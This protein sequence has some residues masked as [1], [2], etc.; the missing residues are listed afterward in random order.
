MF[1]I[2]RTFVVPFFKVS[3]LLLSILSASGQVDINNPVHVDAVCQEVA[4][5]VE[6]INRSIVMK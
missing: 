2:I 4:D 5:A 1:G 3:N 6:S